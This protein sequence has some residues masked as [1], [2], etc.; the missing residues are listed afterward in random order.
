MYWLDRGLFFLVFFGF[1]LENIDILP[2]IKIYIFKKE[3]G[4]E[5]SIFSIGKRDRNAC[6]CFT[7]PIGQKV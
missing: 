2:H 7:R 1:R 5:A 4:M 6:P 3:F